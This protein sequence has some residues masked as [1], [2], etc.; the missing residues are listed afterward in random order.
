MQKSIQVK[1]LEYSIQE[2]PIIKGV[3]FTCTERERLC[4]FGENGAGKSTLLKMICGE[5][6]SDAGQVQKN[7]HIRF[8]YVSQEF[9]DEAKT[10]TVS[11][12]INSVFEGVKMASPSESLY[13]KIFGFA[14]TLGFP[15]ESRLEK[16]CSSMSGGQ[17]KVVTISTALALSP[18]YILLDEPENHLDIV[19]RMALIE[20]LQEFR[21][22]ILFISHDRLLIDSIAT[23][24]GELADGYMHISEGGYDEY[25]EMKMARIGGLQRA[26][27]AE[28]KRIKQ[29]FASIGILAAKAFRGKEVAAYKKAKEELATLKEAHGQ[30][31]RPESKSTKIKLQGTEA[32]LHGGKLLCRVKDLAFKYPEAKGRIFDHANLEVRSGDRIV[33]LGRNGS[34]KS[35]FLKCLTGKEPATAGE[36]VWADGVKWSYFNQHAEFDQEHSALQIVC[37]QLNLDDIDGRAVLGAMR[38]DTHR[39]TTASKHL[40]GG[41][42]MRMRFALAFGAKPDF[43]ILDE[44]TNHIDEVTWEILLEVCKKT[45]SS[46]LLVTHDYE[47]IKEFDPGIFWLIHGQTIAVRYKELDEL[48]DE[49][50]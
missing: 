20:L 27:D 12:Y 5:I 14:K 40:S 41:E 2:R 15:L 49:I 43:I 3:S 8:V 34:G 46:I 21:G 44:P 33:L 48:L 30:S 17:Q 1:K 47:F 45:K 37:Q 18:D 29:L 25:I 16:I 6:E 11:Q 10:K 31:G 39:M 35:T 13:K 36:V 4:I 7:G 26:F 42:R 19:S 24:V 50:R 38:F 9:S 32:R 23:K 22:A 28:A